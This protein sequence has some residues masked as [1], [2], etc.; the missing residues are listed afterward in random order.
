MDLAKISPDLKNLA[1]KCYRARSV[2][3]SSG[4][5]ERFEIEL[6]RSDSREENLPP[7]TGVVGSASGRSGSGRIY[8]VGRATG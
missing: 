8:Q 7:T 3:V 1:G 2:R 5:G 4:F 6:P